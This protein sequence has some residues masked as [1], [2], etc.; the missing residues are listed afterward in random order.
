MR[1]WK[2]DCSRTK[3]HMYPYIPLTHNRKLC[4]KTILSFVQRFRSSVMVATFSSDVD[5]LASVSGL[6]NFSGIGFSL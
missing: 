6:Y 3:K 1:F 5:M 4:V 2:A